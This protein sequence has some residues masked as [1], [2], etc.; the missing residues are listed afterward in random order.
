MRLDLLPQHAPD[1]AARGVAR[2]EHAPNAVCRLSTKG[3]LSAGVA[4]EGD[5]PLD[6]LTHI[7]WTVGDE[8][9]VRPRASRGHHLR[10]C[11]SAK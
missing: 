7:P 2:V 6:Q 4:V 1:L 10:Q 9:P 8:H 11:V 5:A 3:R